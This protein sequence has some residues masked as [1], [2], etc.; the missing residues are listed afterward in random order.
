MTQ[1]HK[2]ARTKKSFVHRPL[3]AICVL[4]ASLAYMQ[5][6]CAAS[7]NSD[8]AVGA[9]PGQF[10]VEHG[11]AN[12]AV[13]LDLPPGAGGMT[14]ELTINYSSNGGNG[15]LGVGWNLTGLTAISRC[16]LTPVE[17]GQHHAPDFSELDRFC[18]DGQRLVVEMGSYGGNG[19]SYKTLSES[20]SKVRSFGSVG[21]GPEYFIVTTKSGQT[22]EF[23]RSTDSRLELLDAG[24]GS[25]VSVAAWSVNKIVDAVGNEIVFHY[26]VDR[27]NGKQKIESIAYSGNE[28]VISY[29]ARQDKEVSYASGH[30]FVVD[31]RVS[32]I[33]IFS[34][35][36]LVSTY[37]FSYQNSSTT[38][39]SLLSA[40]EK[41]ARDKCFSATG[42]S[43]GEGRN[44]FDSVELLLSNTDSPSGQ[45]HNINHQHVGDFNGDGKTDYMWNY[46]GWYVALGTENGLASPKL[47]ISSTNSPSGRTYNAG[48]EYVGDYNGDGKDDF[49]WNY[50][51]W[52][53]A[54]SNGDG[55]DDPIL[56]L[57]NTD[58][59]NGQTYHANAGYRYVADFNGDGRTDYMWNNGGW[60][61]ALSN[62]SGFDYPVQWLSNTGAP[63]GITYHS[64]PGYQRVADF[65]GDGRA[66]YMWNNG[67]WFVAISNGNGFDYPKLWLSNTGSPSGRTYSDETRYQQIGDFN[68][69][70]KADYM[71]N[72]YGWY[73]ALSNGDGF[74]YPKLWLQ[75]TASPAGGTY[76]ANHQYIA[77]FNGDGKSDYMWDWYGLY[78]SL[79]NGDGFDAP[80]LWLGYDESPTGRTYN[81][82]YQYLG[83]FNGD[84]KIDYFW[85]YYGWYIARGDGQRPDTVSK[86]NDGLGSSI[87]FTLDP[88]TNAAVYPDVGAPSNYPER[89]LQAAMYVVSRVT[90]TNGVGGESSTSYRYGGARAHVLGRGFLGFAWDEATDDTTG[91][92]TRTDYHQDYP[93]TGMP[94]QTITQLASGVVVS[95]SVN[96]YDV[97]TTNYTNTLPTP[98]G[99]TRNQIYT[100]NFPYLSQKVDE[101]RELDDSLVS[102]VTS[103][104]ENYDDYGNVRKVTV[105][106]SAGGETYQKI[107]DSTYDNDTTKWHLGRLRT[108]TVTHIDTEAQT[109]SRKSSFEYYP[110]TG[111]LWKEKIE[112]NKPEFKQTTTY[113]YDAFGNKISATVSGAGVTSRTTTSTYDPSGRFAT[114]VSNA[115]GHTETRSYDLYAHCGTAD[116]LTGPN[117]LTT[118]WEYDSFC[119]KTGEIRADGTQ[120]TITRDW[121]DPATDENAPVNAVYYVQEQSSGTPPVTKYFDVLGRAIRAVSTGFDG[122]AIYQDTVYDAQGREFK[123]SLPYYAGDTS[124]WVENQYDILNRVTRK[125]FNDGKRTVTTK[126]SYAGLT[127]TETNTLGQQKTTTKNAL[128]KVA[129]VD[130]EEGAYVTYQYD[131]VGNLTHT[132]QSDSQTGNIV[133]TRMGY[134]V[135][136]RK[137]WMDDPDM[138]RD[139]NPDPNLQPPYPGCWS[140]KY[141]TFGELV[142]QTDAKGQTV[143][144]TYDALGRML[145]RSDKLTDGSVESDSTWVYDNALMAIGKLTLVEQRDS[146]SNLQFKQESAY[147]GYGRPGRTTTTIANDDGTLNIFSNFV[148]YDLYGRVARTVQPGGFEVN[149]QYNLNGYLIAKQSPSPSVGDYDSAH[150]A[151]L[152]DDAVSSAQAALVKADWYATQA[153]YFETKADQYST[154]IAAQAKT[155]QLAVA[156]PAFDDPRG[157]LTYK[158]AGGVLYAETAPTIVII[159]GSIATPIVVAPEQH[160]K[161]LQDAGGQWAATLIDNTAWLA[162]KPSLTADGKKLHVGDFDANGVRDFRHI[163]ANSTD[164]LLDNT[165]LNKLSSLTADIREA[166]RVLANRADNALA[167]AQQLVVAA[168]N[169]RDRERQAQY[170]AT[171][172]GS[173]LNQM[174]ADADAG[175]VTWW[176]ATARDA[177]GRLSAHRLGNGLV[178]LRDY[179][180]ANG[181]LNTIQTGFG[182]GSLV[183]HLEYEYDALD[184][185]TTRYDDTQNVREEFGYD[186]LNRLTSARVA[187]YA[188]GVNYDDTVTYAYDALGNMTYKSDVGDY[189]YGDGAK[190]NLANAGPHAVSRTGITDDYAYDENGSITQTNGRNITWTSFNKPHSFDKAGTVVKFFYGPGRSRFKKTVGG[191]FGVDKTTL[192][193][194]KGYERIEDSAGLVTH[195]YFIHTEDGLTA[196]HVKHEDAGG[197]VDSALDETRYLHRDALG[198]IDTITDGQGNIVERMGYSPFGARRGG[199]W[200]TLGG[201][202]L[203]LYTNRGFTGH[204]HIEEMGL[205]HMNGRVY[206]PEIGRFLSADPHVQFPDASQSYNRYSYVMNNPLKYTDP[207]GYFL[208]KLFKAIKKIFKNPIFRAVVGLVVGI[209]AFA[210]VGIMTGSG[211]LGAFAGGFTGGLIASGGDL[212]QAAIGGITAL[213]FYGIGSY[214]ETLS[215]AS[216]TGLS[217]AQKVAKVISHGVAGGL[218]SRLSGGRFKDGFL[219]A[220]FTQGVS[221]YGNV[222]VEGDIVGNA[223]KAA[224]IGGTASEVGGGKFANGASRAAFGR[225]FNDEVHVSV[226]TRASRWLAQK[227]GEWTGNDNVVANGAS[228]GV[229]ITVPNV[230]YRI[231]LRDGITLGTDGEFDVVAFAEGDLAAANDDSFDYGVAKVRAPSIGWSTAASAKQIEGVAGKLDVQYGRLG[232]SVSWSQDSFGIDVSTKGFGL[233]GAANPT[234]TKTWGLRDALRQ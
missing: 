9:I 212:K 48:W 233:S 90:K 138:S 47:W 160:Y 149:N 123:S 171:A 194:G 175:M 195:K 217:A 200:Q 24:S 213:A 139:C 192:Y 164:P 106:T 226:G 61:V 225:L 60:F 176:R 65:N 191:D 46:N 96:T 145:T 150:L 113:V 165:T 116:S 186:R 19:S 5:L 201:L 202:T 182:Y 188:V 25:V 162:L 126:F 163:A 30:M 161:L 218:S 137:I 6:T 87:A 153:A 209:Y 71:W 103:L 220:G 102:T 173:E 147:D 86:I 95:K 134:D 168:A 85:N 214:F 207:S 72:H 84:G 33:D 184:N 231:S 167:L 115:L 14:P 169:V 18:L 157:Y 100:V 179:D 210:W 22:L 57:S 229:A 17:D 68:G 54:L 146:N 152:F 109:E 56:W 53:V 205:I 26:A 232:G 41:C 203:Q 132:H 198:S 219:S 43:W 13:P 28:V 190:G 170:W 27:D 112:P 110:D 10:S 154:V 4:I 20:F 29:E 8:V 159:H 2:H 208:K 129:R 211:A 114:S 117:G 1:Q 34:D 204:E 158:D 89:Q 196:I 221:Q 155:Q 104:Y 55:F 59:P 52:Y 111:L 42:I 107:T 44:D 187:G 63:N 183:R 131:P 16:G 128:G 80:T 230:W 62:G 32:K 51:G 45:A 234:Y 101:T 199:D 91:I 140:Y 119:R 108:A 224:V 197:Q 38:G 23:G 189:L 82:G 83:D 136:G 177:A 181:H 127:T 193:I 143:T 178:D 174:A 118:R 88:L 172:G 77:D 130:E 67:G 21:N 3:A 93:R 49:M 66:D 39:R 64:N 7:N 37:L 73:V 69:D 185:V 120:S 166:G 223:A 141:N 216:K 99:G 74:E 35:N 215:A 125:V 31:E 151:S 36:S 133:T 92:T 222:F 58:S 148:Y 122:R 75:N 156:A 180:P 227:Y 97:K 70:G 11:A 228:F 144:M 94:K 50:Y 79:S 206:D 78:V 12:Y 121:V 76:N 135:R 98:E 124:Y 81:S 40:V 15:P 105:T 142:S